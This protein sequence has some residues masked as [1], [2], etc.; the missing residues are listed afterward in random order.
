MPPA[1]DVAHMR[2]HFQATI[3]EFP[4]DRDI[5]E[6]GGEIIRAL[7]AATINAQDI[8]D[9]LDAQMVLVGNIDTAKVRTWIAEVRKP[10]ATRGHRFVDMST[11]LEVDTLG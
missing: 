9:Y 11:L 7:N 10:G 5:R 6:R 1:R 4:N 8:L 3:D 2:L